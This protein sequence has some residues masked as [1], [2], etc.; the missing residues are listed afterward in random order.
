[1][2]KLML[3]LGLVAA[4]VVGANAGTVTITGAYQGG[5]NI[6][7][8]PPVIDYGVG[9][10]TVPER[11]AGTAVSQGAV[12]RQGSVIIVAAISGTTS[13]NTTTNT[14]YYTNGVAI[15]TN[16]VVKPTAIVV[17]NSGLTSADGSVYWFKVK[18]NRVGLVL[19]ATISG[20]VT[21]G[22]LTLSDG[23]G[24]AIPV[25]T[26]TRL[27]PADLLGLKSAIYAT[28]TCTN[29]CSVSVQDW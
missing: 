11:E 22:S 15:V 24:G 26:T 6:M 1:M 16:V 25:T 3:L 17:P 28:R 20:T 14:Y 2:K 18:P 12:C 23:D 10:A 9:W 29:A 27:S 13:P 21:S 5:T 8:A 4:V 7:V 19:T